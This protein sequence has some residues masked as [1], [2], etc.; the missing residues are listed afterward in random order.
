MPKDYYKILGVPRNASQEEIK[1]AY[2]RLALKYHPDR[3]RGNKEAEEKFKEINEAYAVLSDP[4]KRRQYDLFGS[5]EFERRFSQED[6][7]RGFNFESIFRDLGIDFDL[8]G[9]FRFGEGS[10]DFTLNLGDLFS[11]LFGTGPR[12][13]QASKET[14]MEL[15]L[16]V[17]LEE[18]L[19]GGEK[20]LMVAPL[21]R[22]EKVKV[23]LP[24]GVKEGQRL[25]LRAKGPLGP[26]GRR[27]DLFLRVKIEPHPRFRREGN[28]LET[29]VKVPLT[30]LLLGGEH[31]VETLEGKRIKVKI[32][33]ATAPGARLRLRGLGLPSG[34]GTR[35]D[36]YLRLEALLP[37]K[38]TSKQKELLKA[39]KEAGL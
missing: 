17:S 29:T 14:E 34:N 8:G 30:T 36:L 37:K 6:I 11:H 38:L 35:G 27:R 12:T 13:Y 25:R 7:F 4:E 32:P 16:P 22:P 18:V 20:V 31:E 23:H 24:P 10:R 33:P 26:D 1:R 2:R 28:D 3:N 9:F 21:G 19:Q 15:E 39:L 5:A